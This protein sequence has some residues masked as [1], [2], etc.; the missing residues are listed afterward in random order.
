[1][2]KITA[3]IIARNEEQNIARSIGSLKGF[4][5]VIVMDS[6]STD[7]TVEIARSMGAAVYQT[8]W[9]GY[10]RQRQRSLQKA[11]NS[12][13]LFLDADEALDAPLNREILN[14]DLA[15][16]ARGYFLKRNNY[17]LGKMIRY[18]RWGND[19]Q[20]RLFQKDSASIPEVDIHEGVLINGPTG[21]LVTGCIKHHTV[22]NLFR[23]LEK[24]NEYTSLEAKQKIREGRR[25]SAFRLLWEPLA[26]FWKLYVVLQGWREG[27]RGLAIAGLSALGRFVVMAKIRE[28]G[29]G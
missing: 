20:L 23:Y 10:A 12:W 21:R 25:F 5:E 3:I 8:D 13:V 4:S 17:F 26:E 19:W 7:R 27:V 28:A 22:P 14:L 11:N 16:P 24:T 2:N 9:P 1:M 29:S 15:G 18:S 6:G